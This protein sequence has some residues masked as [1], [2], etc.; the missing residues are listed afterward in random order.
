M[1]AALTLFA[2]EGFDTTSTNRIAKTAG[3]SEGLIFKHFGNK[4]GL[5][6][7]LMDEVEAKFVNLLQPI[8]NEANPKQ[9]II[10]ALMMPFISVDQKEF[11]YWRLTYKLK[12][13]QGYEYHHKMHPLIEKLSWAFSSLG[14][15]HADKE[16]KLLVQIVDT[17]SLDILRGN[18]E[19]PEAYKN[20]LLAKYQ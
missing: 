15:P 4:L 1:E 17:T 12:F 11:D 16:A 5:L 18:L 7:A 14:Y 13:R 10:Q 9:A 3:V 19:D 20:F 2:H 8:L 6:N